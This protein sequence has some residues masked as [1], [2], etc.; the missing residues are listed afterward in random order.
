MDDNLKM[1]EDLYEEMR[2]SCKCACK[3]CYV[4]E[5]K[6]KYN[7]EEMNIHC[8][9]LYIT[10]KL[11]GDNQDSIDY[12]LNSVAKLKKTCEDEIDRGCKNCKYSDSL[13]TPIPCYGYVIGMAL[14]KEV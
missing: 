14:L 9:A 3:D 10:V 5:L 1:L 4:D 2:E 11:L 13:H 6:K 8:S 12:Y 7:I